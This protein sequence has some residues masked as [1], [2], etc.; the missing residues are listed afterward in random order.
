MHSLLCLF[1]SHCLVGSYV[2]YLH[3]TDSDILVGVDIKLVNYEEKSIYYV[4]ETLSVY[5]FTRLFP[6]LKN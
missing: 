5:S 4:R 3:L 6:H 2:I 1:C